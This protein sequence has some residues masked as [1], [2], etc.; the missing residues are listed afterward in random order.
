[1][2]QAF[3]FADR[4]RKNATKWGAT[5]CKCP[6]SLPDVRPCSRCCRLI[7]VHDGPVA[8]SNPVPRRIAPTVLLAAL[9]A[10]R[11]MPAAAAPGPDAARKGS[12]ADLRPFIEEQ[13]PRWDTNHDGV[14]DLQEINKAIESPAVQ[15]L[16]AATIVATYRQHM[17]DG[18]GSRI[19]VSRDELLTLAGDRK[20][21]K[22]VEGLTKKLAAAEHSLF[23]PADP[24]LAAFHQGRLGDCYLLAA[25]AAAVHRDPQAIREMI[26]PAKNGGFDVVVAGGRKVHVPAITEAELL[27]DLESTAA[28]ASGSR[29]W[30]RPTDSSASAKRRRRKNRCPTP[31][32]PCPT[33]SSA[34]ATPAR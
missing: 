31:R 18:K 27:M 12:E 13:F 4:S 17:D 28:T 3:P 25:I 11:L 21:V 29:S 30:K 10:L 23:L 5:T 9:L 20:F 33:R 8:A 24:D 16:E 15:G 2:S 1:M 34:A 32:P 19:R 26:R 22:T 14:L 6:V 7:A